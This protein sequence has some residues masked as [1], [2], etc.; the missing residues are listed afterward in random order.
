MD[1]AKKYEPKKEIVTK[2]PKK[3]DMV[4]APRTKEVTS[5]ELKDISRFRRDGS[6]VF[7]AE[8]GS[9]YVK[10]VPEKKVVDINYPFETKP[11]GTN[12][13]VVQAPAKEY[14][15]YLRRTTAKSEPVTFMDIA[16]K[17]EPKKPLI[18]IE[19]KAV[20]IL[21]K[22]PQGTTI[23]KNDKI[24]ILKKQ[25][26]IKKYKAPEPTREIEGKGGLI[27]LQKV[28][29]KLEP[30]TT[31]K[32]VKV[33]YK[34]KSQP[35]EPELK[36]PKLVGT[37]QKYQYI[38]LYEQKAI[39]MGDTKQTSISLI[40]SNAER[41][42][43]KSEGILLLNLKQKEETKQK[44]IIELKPLQEQKKILQPITRTKIVS[45]QEPITRVTTIQRVNTIQE[46]ITR[47]KVDTKVDT[48]TET[49]IEQKPILIQEVIPE[50]PT[51]LIPFPKLS[52]DKKSQRIT[53]KVREKG[54]WKTEG[55]YSDVE[56]A[57]KRGIQNIKGT[58]KASFKVESMGRAININEPSKEFY[59]S[60]KEKGVLIQKR[61]F[62]ISSRGEKEEITLKGLQTI[63]TKKGF[64]LFKR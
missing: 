60:S 30:K 28:E 18:N 6:N 62:R 52:S 51:K 48:K 16:K 44:S 34:Q 36:E 37:E 31:G 7:K 53:L 41:L 4:N 22:E 12:S 57:T 3:V 23:F 45:I 38:E 42:K 43:G 47:T 11:I 56:S 33:K 10:I 58:S 35:K 46:P 49:R 14:Y 27:L 55:I 64:N 32:R 63:R 15:K 26:E 24:E 54:Q 29:I 61:G 59:K 2:A 9:T 17:Y 21:K 25:P 39:S 50:I 40:E 5:F 13:S 20:E 1:I 19:P 8:K